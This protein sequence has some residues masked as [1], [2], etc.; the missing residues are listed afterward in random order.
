M[1][2][3]HTHPRNSSPLQ[4]KKIFPYNFAP[5]TC[6]FARNML[7]LHKTKPFEKRPTPLSALKN[8]RRS[9]C[10]STLATMTTDAE[11]TPRPTMA[12]AT[13][14]AVG[15]PDAHWYVALVQ[16]NTEKTVASR[17]AEQGYQTYVALQSEVRIWSRNRRRTV[18]RV[19]IPSVVFVHCT[20]RQ[21][22][23][24]VTL[25]YISRFMTNR[26]ASATELGH[27]PLAIVPDVQINILRFMLGQ[28]D[29]PVTIGEPLQ[30]GDHVR[31]VRGHLRGLEGEIINNPDGSSELIVLLNFF[32]CA[33]L[34]IAPED[35]EKA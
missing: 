28:T 10:N 17:L 6:Q 25:P 9:L 26:A 12:P 19:V 1:P 2:I 8:R 11:S 23:Q 22:R 13:A 7:N 30:A 4:T 29:T 32:G 27:K 16:T 5:K 31:I 24:I 3:K 34:T 15:L 18:D 35:V 14:D 21:R 33:R 20:E